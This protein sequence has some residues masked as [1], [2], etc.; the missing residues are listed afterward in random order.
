VL[1]RTMN[2]AA[3]HVWPAGKLRCKLDVRFEF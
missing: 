3:L 1:R 2:A